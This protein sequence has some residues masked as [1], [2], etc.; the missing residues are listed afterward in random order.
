MQSEN[1]RQVCPIGAFAAKVRNPLQVCA[2]K[3]AQGFPPLALCTTLDASAQLT[4]FNREFRQN[5]LNCRWL[6]IHK[7]S[8]MNCAKLLKVC[9]HAERVAR[10]KTTCKRLVI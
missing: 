4:P 8:G 3:V 1:H 9:L 2:Q 7:V 5:S 6:R 10:L